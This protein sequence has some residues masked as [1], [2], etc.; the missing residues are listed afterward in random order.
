MLKNAKYS[1][2]MLGVAAANRVEGGP[3]MTGNVLV[4][5]T[6]NLPISATPNLDDA[7]DN[8][9]IIA[10]GDGTEVQSGKLLPVKE[11]K[12][13]ES[14]DYTGHIELVKGGARLRVS[15]WRR[16]TSDTGKTFISLTMAPMSLTGEYNDEPPAYEISA[17]IIAT[18]AVKAASTTA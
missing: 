5:M 16:K 1:A 4:D 9:F 10:V 11:K 12:T 2:V 8:I 14:P 3:L 7:G 15:A 6:A 13:P 18:L 17:A